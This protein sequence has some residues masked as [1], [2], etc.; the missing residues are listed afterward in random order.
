MRISSAVLHLLHAFDWTS[1]Q[2]QRTSQALPETGIV[3]MTEYNKEA[4][5]FKTL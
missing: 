1:E 3:G 2:M 4:M 5:S